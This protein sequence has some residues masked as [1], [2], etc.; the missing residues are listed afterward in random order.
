V[1]STRDVAFLARRA[2]TTCA[3][4]IPAQREATRHRKFLGPDAQAWMG[5]INRSKRPSHCAMSD[6]PARHRAAPRRVLQAPHLHEAGDPS[7]DQ[8]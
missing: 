3:A 7:N 6:N 4:V 5:Q 8:S 1:T 2:A